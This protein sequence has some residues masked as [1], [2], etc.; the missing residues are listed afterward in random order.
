LN[1]AGTALAKASQEKPIDFATQIQPIFD[2][3]CATSFCHAGT[4]PPQGL[5]LEAGK[6]YDSIVEVLSGESSTAM[7]VKP[8]DAENSYLY[9]KLEGEQADLGGGGGRMPFGKPAL[10]ADQLKLIEDWIN[11][12]ALKEPPTTAVAASAWGE[13]KSLVNAWAK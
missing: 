12:G 4:N 5:N 7:R 8:F 1:W 11:Q 2:R 6:S 9:R 13:V 3:S 10:A